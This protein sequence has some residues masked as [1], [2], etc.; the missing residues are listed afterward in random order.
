[1]PITARCRG[2]VAALDTHA[3]PASRK[4]PS[5]SNIKYW[6]EN[7]SVHFISAAMG[8]GRFWMAFDLRRGPRPL[9]EHLRP[10]RRHKPLK[11]YAS[12][13]FVHSA[14][15]PP[16]PQIPAPRIDAAALPAAATV[17]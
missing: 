1:M 5:M 12:G 2:S 13:P 8:L 15:Y 11:I 10:M 17:E 6:S 3:R 4:H 16:P 9:D 7:G 14:D